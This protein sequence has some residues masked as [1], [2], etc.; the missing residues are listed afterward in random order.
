MDGQVSG[1]DVWELG[2]KHG[3]VIKWLHVFLYFPPV[4]EEN[5]L[6]A[7]VSILS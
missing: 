5:Y 1:K 4:C 2:F 6:Q 7:K 3:L